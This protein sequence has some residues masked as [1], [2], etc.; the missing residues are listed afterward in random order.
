MRTHAA[1]WVLAVALL[2]PVTAHAEVQ[3]GKVVFDV[4]VLRPL[5]FV[6]SLIGAGLFVPVALV[7]LPNGVDSV[8]EALD[9]MVI[10]PGKHVYTRPLGEW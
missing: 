9:Q 8:Q 4:L 3:P 2:A 7:T 1:I 5:G 10:T 6:A